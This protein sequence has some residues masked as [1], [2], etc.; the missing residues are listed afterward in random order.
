MKQYRRSEQSWITPSEVIEYL[1][2]PRFCYFMHSL[3]I[4]QN[5]DQRYKVIIGRN[6]HK[7]KMRINKEYLRKKLRVKDK[8]IDVY[9]SSSKYGIRGIIDEVLTLNDDTMSPLDYKFAKFEGRIYDT[10]KY[11]SV[12][13]AILI[14]EN[15][16]FPV[17]KGFICFIRS[18]NSIQTI[19][20]T[21]NEKIKALKIIEE[22]FKV[23][24]LGYFPKRTKNR[25]KCIDCC[26]R[27]I[28]VK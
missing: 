18:N 8:L 17:N 21:E 11:Q 5:E 2:C 19:D 9:L 7:L 3:L 15:F 25:N 24:E 13:Y 23:I 20:I 14:E 27:N 10:L 12:L 6:I 22:M 16:N 1:Y 26:Y 28:C 4:P